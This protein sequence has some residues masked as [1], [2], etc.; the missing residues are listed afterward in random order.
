MSVDEQL[1]FEEE[2]VPPSLQAEVEEELQLEPE[3]FY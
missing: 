3:K 2:E 1:K